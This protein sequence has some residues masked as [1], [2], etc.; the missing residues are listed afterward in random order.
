MRTGNGFDANVFARGT[1]RDLN[2]L[3]MVYK[4]KD[5]HSEPVA[6]C[7][8]Y[9]LSPSVSVRWMGGMTL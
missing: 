4:S 1:A 2:I 7:L 9:K 5:A 6:Q 3:L 8:L